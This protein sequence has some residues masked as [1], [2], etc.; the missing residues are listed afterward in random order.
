MNNLK[1]LKA[2][3]Q[4]EVDTAFLYENIAAIQNDANLS[5]VL[6]GLA[7]IEKRTCQTN[8]SKSERFGRRLP[9]AIGF[10]QSQNA[11]KSRKIFWI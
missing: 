11:I 4:T 6:N 1:K 10:L 9:N 2:Q 7:D 8:F 3:L 5:K